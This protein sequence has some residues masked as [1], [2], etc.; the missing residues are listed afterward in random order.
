MS[1]SGLGER[2]ALDLQG[3][4]QLKHTV[5]SDSASGLSEVSKQFEAL[6][7]QTMFKSMREAIPQS[8]LFDSA[9]TQ[10]Y[11]EL[12][13]Q[14]WA[15]HLAGKGLGL[16]EQ[17]AEQMRRMLPATEAVEANLPS[18]R[19][20]AARPLYR[21]VP[22]GSMYFSDT[23]AAPVA[24]PFDTVLERPPHVES[25]LSHLQTPAH[26]A[27]RDSGLPAELILAQAALETG[28]GRRRITTADGK[29]SHNLF[30][31]KAGSQW[32]GATTEVVTTEYIDGKALKQVEKFRVY[33]N[34]HAAFTDYVRLISGH[35]RYAAVSAAPNAHQAAHALQEAGYASDPAYADKLIAVMESIGTLRHSRAQSG[36]NNL[37]IREQD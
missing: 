34:H 12:L 3:L 15:Q 13:D 10:L 19:P 9:Q 7:L 30:G 17:L 21:S 25:F 28:W 8:G 24:L 4:Q 16:A 14:Q 35:P 22:A 37:A 33:P 18:T 29:D 27:S 26:Q 32:R 23:R 11:T 36:Q 2:F 6:F 1:V 20:Q 5:R 31:I